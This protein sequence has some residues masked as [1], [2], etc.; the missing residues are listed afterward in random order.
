MNT[1]THYT[2]RLTKAQTRKLIAAALVLPWHVFIC[3]AVA[4]QTRKPLDGYTVAQVAK[5]GARN[6]SAKA[7]E[8]R[9]NGVAMFP[10]VDAS[11][12][13][14]WFERLPLVKLSREADALRSFA[15]ERAAYEVD[16]VVRGAVE[17][18]V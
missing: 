17:E 5:V 10:P 1:R 2:D 4:V 6:P 11:T 16:R 18:S 3:H 9:F 7:W 14:S 13:Y 12:A 8:I 15:Y